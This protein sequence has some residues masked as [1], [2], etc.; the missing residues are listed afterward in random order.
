MARY[1]LRE[2][3][4]LLR[5]ADCLKSEQETHLNEQEMHLN[6]QEMIFMEPKN[7]KVANTHPKRGRIPLFTGVLKDQ[8]PPQHPPQ[9]SPQHPTI[10][11]PET[12]PCIL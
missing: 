11:Q 2:T 3:N 4:C 7:V 8:H 5:E 6:E 9:H 12:P 1:F 10:T